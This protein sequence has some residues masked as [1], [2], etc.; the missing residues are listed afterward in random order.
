MLLRVVDDQKRTVDSRNILVRL[1]YPKLQLAYERRKH[2]YAKLLIVPEEN[3][4]LHCGE[5]YAAE[6]FSHLLLNLESRRTG[7]NASV[8]FVANGVFFALFSSERHA[9]STTAKGSDTTSTSAA[10]ILS[11]AG[12][13]MMW[14]QRLLSSA[15]EHYSCAS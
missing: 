2:D 3:P 13:L 1:T 6:S 5:A 14:M 8:S 4:V 15:R 9:R 7:T 10:L 11:R 12:M